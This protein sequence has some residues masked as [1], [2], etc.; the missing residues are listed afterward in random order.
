VSRILITDDD[1]A[2][3][4]I[5]ERWLMHHDVS[6][7]S[8]ISV[9]HSMAC[10]WGLLEGGTKVD[11]IFLDLTIPPDS[12]ATIIAQIPRLV[13]FCPNI[14]VVTGFPQYK[15]ACESAGCCEFLVKPFDTTTSR[16]FFEKIAKFFREAKGPS[17]IE[18]QV[19][20]LEKMISP[21]EQSGRA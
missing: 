11:L 3:T 21:P 9:C 20:H 18:K 14:V 17:P 19:E 15:E 16:T 6:R 5:V 12:P 10:V 1:E 7:D 2:F 13:T 8:Q 4:A